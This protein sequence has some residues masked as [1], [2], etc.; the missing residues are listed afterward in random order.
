[1]CCLVHCMGMIKRSRKLP[2]RRNVMGN[3]WR[4]N[5]TIRFHHSL[6]LFPFP[7]RHSGLMRLSMSSPPLVS[8]CS[9]LRSTHGENKSQYKGAPIPWV[10]VKS[11]ESDCTTKWGMKRFSQKGHF[12]LYSVKEHSDQPIMIWSMFKNV[13]HCGHVSPLSSI[14]SPLYRHNQV[15]CHQWPGVYL[16]FQSFAVVHVWYTSLAIP[17]SDKRHRCV[18]SHLTTVHHC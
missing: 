13:E 14:F 3:F 5:K 12:V 9:S 11:A 18:Q 2:W 15:D 8:R 16:P 7:V 10:P 1:M 17:L 4:R 6:A